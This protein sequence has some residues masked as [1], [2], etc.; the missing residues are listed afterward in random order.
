MGRNVGPI[1]ADDLWRD[2]TGDLKRIERDAYE[3]FSIRRQFREMAQL[4]EHNP[5]LQDVGGNLW[6]WL[7]HLYA[8]TVL[9]RFR[10][11]VDTQGN[12]V[13]LRTLLHEIEARPDVLTR[14]RIAARNPDIDPIVAHVIDQNFTDHWRMIGSRSV[15]ALPTDAIDPSIVE[16]DRVELEATT[17]LL[18]EV[19]SRTIAHRSRVEPTTLA[20]PGADALFDLLERLLTKYVSLIIGSSVVN[21]EPTPQYDTLEA[22]TFPWHRQAFDLWERHQEEQDQE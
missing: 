18:V 2:W 8:S 20:V 6:L 16:A 11:E 4:F 9:M 7:R 1:P 10:R 5:R 17:E 15:V 14:A 13:N 22:F 3:L 21:W 19:T 12:T